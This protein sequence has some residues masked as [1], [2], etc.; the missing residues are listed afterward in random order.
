MHKALAL[1]T[2][3]LTTLLSAAG[4]TPAQASEKQ[5]ITLPVREAEIAEVN[6][7]FLD[8]SDSCRQCRAVNF[9][10]VSLVNYAILLQ[11]LHEGGIDARLQPVPSP[12]SERSRKMVSSG[13][14]HIK[15]DW[16]FNIDADDSVLK[17]APIILNG[18]LEKGLYGRPDATGSGAEALFDDISKLRAVSVRNWR[19]D[20][21]VLEMLGPKSLNSAATMRQMFAMIELHRADFTL[22][23]FSSAPD[24]AREIDGIRLIP[25]AGVKVSLPASQH[26][27]VSRHL[28][29]AEKIVA[30]INYGIGTLREQGFI[31]RCMVNSGMI[32]EQVADWRILNQS[33]ITTGNL[34]STIPSN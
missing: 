23:E 7:C 32:S 20:W 13:S 30:A 29:D 18:E 1:L 6:S 16:S 22:L 25:F 14:A 33:S 19:L 2:L 21:Q 10:N 9:G 27:M 26:F 15:V 31:R 28:P 24:L 4:M 34:V 5:V 8:P 3:F 11:A 17:T 12:N